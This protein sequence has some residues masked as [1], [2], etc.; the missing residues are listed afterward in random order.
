MQQ[1]SSTP[2]H[3]WGKFVFIYG[4]IAVSFLFLGCYSFWHL[5]RLTVP[6]AFSAVLLNVATSLSLYLAFS[7]GAIAFLYAQPSHTEPGL[8]LGKHLHTGQLSPASLGLFGGYI[9]AAYCWWWLRHSFP[10]R[11]LSALL[12]RKHRG[13]MERA[14]DRIIE[15]IYLGRRCAARE[16]PANLTFL[17]DLTAEFPRIPVPPS[18]EY[19]CLPTLDAMSPPAEVF[20]QLV[21]EAVQVYRSDPSA[22]IFVHCA[23]GHG[24]SASF[25]AAMLIKLGLASSIDAAEQLLQQ[26]RPTVKLHGAQRVF[27]SSLKL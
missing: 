6:V 3:R 26:H 10:V 12:I 14:H 21:D 17:V 4:S 9:L 24:R 25:V 1:G 15:R 18:V 7:F 19:R 11:R 5:P 20:L 2:P 23:N 27:L 22:V 13:Q 16:L 8:L